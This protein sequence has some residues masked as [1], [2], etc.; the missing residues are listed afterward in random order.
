[1]SKVSRALAV[2]LGGLIF[3]A[4]VIAVLAHHF[5]LVHVIERAQR[6]V[7]Q[8]EWWGA[9]LYP[10]LIALCNLL[11]LPGGI[12]TIGSG[13]LFGLWWGTSLVLAGNVIGA[14]AAFWI[15]RGLGRQWVERRILQ[16]K[17]WALLDEAIT[18]E[19]WKIIFLSQVHPLFPTSLINY[20]YGVTR[21][22]FSTCLLWVTL[23][24]MPGI[25]MYA[26]FGTLAQLGIKLMR[27]K[28]HP[29][30]QEYVIWIGGLVLTLAITTMLG[31]IA[32]RLLAEAERAVEKEHPLNG[33]AGC[34]KLQVMNGDGLRVNSLSKPATTSA[35]AAAN[36]EQ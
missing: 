35:T 26:Y 33:C 5:D 17:K 3:L 12:L 25:F 30:A 10:L 19:G 28:T 32:L 7:G 14:A 23:G 21:I 15:S 6:K 4:V 16:R 8:M 13:L 2:Q 29:H 31:R 22:R 18:R 36:H 11:L 9:L 24:Q 20:L 1:M 34:P 27:H